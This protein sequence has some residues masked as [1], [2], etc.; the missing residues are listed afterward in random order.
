MLKQT[1]QYRQAET[2]NQT[3][4]A[5]ALINDCVN[6]FEK[7]NITVFHDGGTPVKAFDKDHKPTSTAIIKDAVMGL[8]ADLFDE[9]GAPREGA[10]QTVQNIREIA[11]QL[12]KI[13]TDPNKGV[14]YLQDVH[15]ATLTRMAVNMARDPETTVAL[16]VGIGGSADKNT[17][18]RFTA[19][20]LTP[21]D[22]TRAVK[23]FYTTREEQ[24]IDTLALSRAYVDWEARF[25]QEQGRLPEKHETKQ[26]KN[27]LRQSPQLHDWVSEEDRQ[28][29]RQQYSVRT[30]P[31]PVEFV[32]AYHAAREINTTMDEHV[33]EHRAQ[34]NKKALEEDLQVYFPDL[35]GSVNVYFDKPWDRHST[36][37]T[38]AIRYLA[39]LLRESNDP[40]VQKALK[41]LKVMGENHGGEDGAE[42]AAEYAGAHPAF[43]GDGLK[44]PLDDSLIEQPTHPQFRITVGG[45]PERHFCLMRDALVRTASI[46]GLKAYIN[47]YGGNLRHNARR[48]LQQAL[49]RA[50]NL[51]VDTQTVSLISRVG[52]QATYYETTYDIARDNGTSVTSHVDLLTQIRD[53]LVQQRNA[54]TN[55]R[56]QALRDNL[57]Q[58][59]IQAIELEGLQIAKEIT[60]ASAVLEDYQ[61]RQAMLQRPTQGGRR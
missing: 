16:R 15:I 44:I 25:V 8:T 34:T 42:R 54:L 5:Q 9:R 49:E 33:L 20:M 24:K 6:V 30:Q 59:A 37:D 19:Y 13:L 38:M 23:E 21:L 14:K 29:V 40:D 55:Q 46:E 50:R 47:D 17:T 35:K 41:R 7:N 43:F 2:P 53:N 27:E 52:E 31:I 39:H 57:P 58:D 1:E 10:E 61:A 51:T 11:P 45:E 12:I 28:N 26:A 48:D 60:T 22:I 56:K 36:Y 32:I 18:E 4:Q 3:E